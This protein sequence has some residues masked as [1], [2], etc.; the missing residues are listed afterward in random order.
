MS[1]NGDFEV[2]FRLK[3]PQPALLALIASGWAPIYPGHVSPRDMRS[4]PIGTGPFKIRRV[5]AERSHPGD[6]K[7]GL[8]ERGPESSMVRPVFSPSPAALRSDAS[9]VALRAAL[10]RKSGLDLDLFH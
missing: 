9:V 6:E 3:R 2:T 1:T 8:L 10:Y 5:Q 7:S 4:R